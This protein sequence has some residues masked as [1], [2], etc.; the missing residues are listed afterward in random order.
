[1]HRAGLAWLGVDPPV[2]TLPKMTGGGQ[3]LVGSS[4]HDGMT[5]PVSNE[6]LLRVNCG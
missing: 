4:S 3:G 2:S 5:R 6:H 1:M